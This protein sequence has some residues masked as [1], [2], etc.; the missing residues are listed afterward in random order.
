MHSAPH[1]TAAAKG[2]WNPEGQ[3][4]LPALTIVFGHRRTHELLVTT[5]TQV[6]NATLVLGVKQGAAIRPSALTSLPR[7][8]F[9]EFEVLVVSVWSPLLEGHPYSFSLFQTFP[10][11]MA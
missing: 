9:E 8:P 4:G 5:P 1:A 3:H 11:L 7:S 6:Q 10:K 2:P